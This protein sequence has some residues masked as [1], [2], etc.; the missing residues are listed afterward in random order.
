M[1]EQTPNTSDYDDHG[2]WVGPCLDCGTNHDGY[3]PDTLGGRVRC[4]RAQAEQ[5]GATGDLAA[6]D[7]FEAD[8]NEKR[9]AFIARHF[10]S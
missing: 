7:A 1:A 9:D 10:Q 8:F 2:H 6:L 5:T 4:L 3:A